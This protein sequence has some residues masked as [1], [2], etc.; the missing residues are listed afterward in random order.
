MSFLVEY[1]YIFYWLWL[2]LL[3]K[4]I[5]INLYI[6]NKQEDKIMDQLSS[7]FQPDLEAMIL[8]LFTFRWNLEEKYKRAFLSLLK[9]ANY[10]HII[11]IIYTILIFI[12]LLLTYGK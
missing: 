1:N 12:L 5:F 10:L 9:Y 11:F 7:F 2:A 4:R 3:F 6:F 8:L